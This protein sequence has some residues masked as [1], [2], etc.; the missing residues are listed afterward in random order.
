MPIAAGAQTERRG[1]AEP[2]RD[3]LGGK[4]SPAAFL[5]RGLPITNGDWL[6]LRLFLV[7]WG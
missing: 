3:S 7:V 4:T 2:V 6:V 1:E 5:Q